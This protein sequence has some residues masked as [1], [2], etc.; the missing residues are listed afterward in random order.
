MPINLSTCILQRRHSRAAQWKS[1]PQQYT[2]G[3]QPK[4]NSKQRVTAQYNQ[5]K[6]KQKLNAKELECTGIST[7]RVNR[8]LGSNL[9]AILLPEKRNS[10]QSS[11]RDFKNR[12]PRNNE[13]TPSN[14]K[15]RKQ[16]LE[17]SSQSSLNLLVPFLSPE[18]K[19]M[20]K[21]QSSALGLGR[22]RKRMKKK[23]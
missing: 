17:M 21:I 7:R 18:K 10:L 4:K 11:L 20:K 16:L 6:P 12:A 3:T 8:G 2:Q 19:R 23:S 5:Q 15:N 22:E 14:D 13:P 1:Q 9:K